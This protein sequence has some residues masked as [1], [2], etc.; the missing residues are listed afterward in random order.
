MGCF[1]I[2]LMTKAAV[3]IQENA[4]E[5]EAYSQVFTQRV[6]RAFDKLDEDAHRIQ[7]QAY[8]KMAEGAGPEADEA[9]ASEAAYFEGV[10]Y[11]QVTNAIRQ[12]VFNLM[13]AGLY[14]LL[15]QQAA[16]MV[17][18]VLPTPRRPPQDDRYPVP[19]MSHVMLER[20]VDLTKFNHWTKLD[21]LRLVANAVKH[22]D[23]VSAEKLKG[24]R[25]ELFESPLDLPRFASAS[26]PPI[27]PLV[28]EGM[29]LTE[30]DFND[31]AN[32]L[33]G[34]W[35]ELEPHLPVFDPQR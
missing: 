5:V 19:V 10:G 9:W 4:E 7:E 6:A 2:M 17:K 34:F 23:G 20:G 16:K 32:T 31:Y 27:R 35:H 1:K 21:D 30:D 3:T 13:V 18:E 15:E 8:A 33:K 28:G 12:G 11:Y 29:W 14:H 24:R 22:G 25:P 26:S